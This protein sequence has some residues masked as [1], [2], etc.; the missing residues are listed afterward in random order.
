MY[1]G[2]A[3]PTGPPPPAPPPMTHPHPMGAQYDVHRGRYMDSYRYDNYRYEEDP[4]YGARDPRYDYLRY[5]DYYHGAVPPAPPPRAARQWPPQVKPDEHRVLPPRM[6]RDTLAPARRGPMHPRSRSPVV[7]SDKE[8]Q[9]SSRD[10][11]RDRNARAGARRVEQRGERGSKTYNRERD[12]DDAERNREEPRRSRERDRDRETSDRG[13]DGRENRENKDPSRVTSESNVK[14]SRRQRR[15]H[16][17]SD[18]EKVSHTESTS[19]KSDDDHDKAASQSS[20]SEKLKDSRH[21]RKT[22]HHSKS[23]SPSKKV[24]TSSKKGSKGDVG[25]SEADGSPRANK[26][27]KKK[28]SKKGKSDGEGA[29]SEDAVSERSK[30][31]SDKE[32]KSSKDEKKPLAQTESLSVD[33]DPKMEPADNGSVESKKE[34]DAKDR[35]LDSEDIKTFDEHVPKDHSLRDTDYTKD[36]VNSGHS[37]AV[38]PED[39]LTLELTVDLKQENLLDQGDGPPSKDNEDLTGGMNY[40]SWTRASGCQ[41]AGP[42]LESEEAE[43]NEEDGDQ[44]LDGS[45]EPVDENVLTAPVPELSKWELDDTDGNPPDEELDPSAEYSQQRLKTKADNKQRGLPPDI[46]QRAE[47]AILQKAMKAIQSPDPGKSGRKA[48]SHRSDV[49]AEATTMAGSTPKE[50]LGSESESGRRATEK[51]STEPTAKDSP[52]A[53]RDRVRLDRSKFGDRKERGDDGSSG[54][55][56]A[57]HSRG[58]PSRDDSKEKRSDSHQRDSR[59]RSDSNSNRARSTTHDGGSSSRRN[60]DDSAEQTNRNSRQSSDSSSRYRNRQD[61]GVI[62]KQPKSPERGGAAT[63]TK[64]SPERSRRNSRDR[65]RGRQ[66]QHSEG[67]DNRSSREPSRS[68]RT[69]ERS[70]SSRSGRDRDPTRKDDDRSSHRRDVDSKTVVSASRD[71]GGGG[72]GGGGSKSPDDRKSSSKRRSESEI[73]NDDSKLETQSSEFKKSKDSS[74]REDP[75]HAPN[76]LDRRPSTID[77]SKFEPDYDDTDESTLA[78]VTKYATGAHSP[79][80]KDRGPISATVTVKRRSTSSSSSSSPSRTSSPDSSS[81]SHKRRKSSPS[82]GTEKSSKHKKGKHKKHKKHKHK[83]K[84]KKSKKEKEDDKDSKEVKSS[85]GRH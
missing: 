37:E 59:S 47:K 49:K 6:P 73:G 70:V 57:S 27:S 77:E 66:E 22:H 44:T 71:R 8:Q 32:R 18:K 26:S 56:S 15:S 28:K 63:G 60:R 10:R 82:S 55:G 76:R 4:R 23:E 81:P 68:D 21:K 51:V 11:D 39:A 29:T 30:S 46:V 84:K 50:E 43:D 20:S 17:T 42:E 2:P 12:R 16:E 74:E 19:K 62:K 25:S 35:F 61:D 54:S 38:F 53:G 31:N 75:R 79:A 52:T 7:T 36:E 33:K 72:V 41:E 83:H 40:A 5:E 64:R 9:S 80:A 48:E 3:Q 1:R 78:A 24:K 14:S 34:V 67:R 85:V 45:L 65:D 13:R 58:R 69:S